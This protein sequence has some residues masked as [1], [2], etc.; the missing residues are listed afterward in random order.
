[1]AVVIYKKDTQVFD[2]IYSRS[3]EEVSPS[4]GPDPNWIEQ[5]GNV[6]LSQLVGKIL[7]GLELIAALTRVR[8]M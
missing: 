1:M 7:A 4:M 6:V 8:K 5:K 3:Y 2:R